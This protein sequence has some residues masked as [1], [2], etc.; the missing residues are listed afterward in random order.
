MQNRSAEAEVGP[1]A[2]TLENGGQAAMSQARERWRLQWQAAVAGS[3]GGLRWRVGGGGQ[4]SSV[5][6]RWVGTVGGG[7]GQR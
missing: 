2:P 6:L 4:G 7:G 5:G 1:V 3:S